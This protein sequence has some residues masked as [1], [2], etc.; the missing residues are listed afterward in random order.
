LRGKIGISTKKALN[1]FKKKFSREKREEI[2]EKAR[3]YR[4]QL[5]K[6]LKE[7]KAEREVVHK[8]MTENYRLAVKKLKE[9]DG[10]DVAVNPWEVRRMADDLGNKE[11]NEK[12]K[13]LT[14]KIRELSKTILKLQKLNTAYE[15]L[16]EVGL[17]E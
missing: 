16:K 14:R 4:N 2:L 11:L 5:L 10:W 17:I 8:K 3:E 15:V 6:Q 12:R 9:R 1:D 13:E 7:L